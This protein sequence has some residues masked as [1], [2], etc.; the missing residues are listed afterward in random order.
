MIYSAIQT[1]EAPKNLEF[2]IYLDE[3][4]YFEVRDFANINIKII[5]GP[6]MPISIMMNCAYSQS[7][8]Q[9]IMYAADDIIFRTEKWDKKVLDIFRDTNS[10]L[11]FADDLSPNTPR[12]ATHGF[13]SR[14]ATNVLGY[15]IPPYFSAD[16]CDT[17]L[18]KLARQTKGIYYLE[19]VIIEHVHPHWNKAE[20]DSTYSD[21]FST[22]SFFYN[23]I[24]YQMHFWDYLK[25]K[26]KLKMM[27][28]T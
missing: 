16:F 26:K 17:F 4:D 15:L 22:N 14:T 12:I 25:D 3:A 13:V 8:G 11:V 5:R 21:K 23:Y 19:K 9:I 1:A 2:C 20:Y 6:K 10:W 18:T 28:N 24:K 27:L 7:A